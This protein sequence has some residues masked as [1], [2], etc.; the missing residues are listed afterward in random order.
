MRSKSIKTKIILYIISSLAIMFLLMLF[1]LNFR[2][3]NT[4]L[5]N[6]EDF[7][8]EI[9]K[10]RSDEISQWLK[11]R[12]EDL[13]VIST[14]RNY[15]FGIWDI[16][17]DDLDLEYNR[18]KDLLALMFFSD[19]EGYYY[20]TTD[21]R[22]SIAE[23]KYFR[24]LI[25]ENLDFVVSDG[26]YSISSGEKI[27]II[28]HRIYDSYDNFVGIV[29]SSISLETISEMLSKIDLVFDSYPWIIDSN[30]YY[31]AHPNKEL[32]LDKNL[33]KYLRD[34]NIEI[35]DSLNKII[36]TQYDN[37]EKFLV[38]SEIENTPGWI[39]GV[40]IDEKELL[41]V[42]RSLAFQFFIIISVFLILT[43]FI[44]I[45]IS[46]KI[47][48]PI[49]HLKNKID[50]FSKGNENINFKNY[51]NDELGVISES[52]EYLKDTTIKQKNEL[53]YYSKTDPLTDLLNRRG[54]QEILNT[55]INKY[56]RHKEKFSILICDLDFFK[57]V[58]DKLGHQT[59]DLVLKRISSIMKKSLRNID[60]ISRWGGEEFL[61]LLP[62]TDK[63]GV[64]SVAEKL[65]ESI[66]NY[67]MIFDD[68]KI[69]V[70]ITIGAADFV[71]G[72]NIDTCVKRADENLYK[73]KNMGRNCVVY[74]GSKL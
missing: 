15:Q 45:I 52:L 29:G 48:N 71:E 27:F 50:E 58:N 2:T 22:G 62:Y 16:M 63:K 12:I 44:L 17:K 20:T 9:V 10:A 74:K 56:Y 41:E 64:I 30:G 31:I 34:Q 65:R 57:S 68:K 67:E 39:L 72:D 19:P 47:V 28:A 43:S 26:L 33:E 35:K 59:G 38:F 61:I 18:R 7:A 32:L 4:I 37:G 21:F 36:K 24:R 60:S 73:G 46:D 6:T 14:K 69:K 53:L 5:Q 49:L 54:M 13:E 42:S 66:E 11:A 55:Q 25:D 40:T 8:N 3:S 70:T 51:R 1:I 23:R